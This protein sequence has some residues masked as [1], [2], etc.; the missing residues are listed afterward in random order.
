MND[1]QQFL[2]YTA[3]SGAVRV[4]VVFKA[5]SVWLTQKSLADLFGV[6]VPAINKHLKNIYESGELAAQ[7]TISKLETVQSEGRRQIARELDYYNLDAIIA[8]G[9]RANSFQATQFRIWATQTLRESITKGFV[10]DDDRLKQA[11]AATIAHPTSMSSAYR[12]MRASSCCV[13]LGKCS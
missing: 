4:Q 7:A 11:K 2:L 10:M 1:A 3:P 9:Y 13:T 8:V 5:E 6:Q 12:L